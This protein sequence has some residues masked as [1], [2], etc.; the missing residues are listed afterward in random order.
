MRAGVL[1]RQRGGGP[2]GGSHFRGWRLMNPQLSL[3]ALAFLQR[4]A[5]GMRYLP[6]HPLLRA[7]GW[8]SSLT[9]I[10]TAAGALGA[11]S[12][13]W[14]AILLAALVAML[15]CRRPPVLLCAAA[16]LAVL[17]F[18]GLLSTGSSGLVEMLLPAIPLALAGCGVDRLMERS[19]QGL[20][21]SCLVLPGLLCLLI[22]LVG[23]SIPGGSPSALAGAALR[24]GLAPAGEGRRITLSTGAAAWLEMPAAGGPRLGA[25]FLHGARPH[26]SR[27]PAA[28]QVRRA[29]LE[30]GLVV[31]SV[32]H[33]GYGASPVPPADS[34]LSAWDPLPT[35]EAALLALRK[36]SGVEGVIVVGHLT[37]AIDALRLLAADRTLSGA[38]LLGPEFPDRQR[39]TGTLG[40]SRFHSDR[41]MEKRI[42][43]RLYRRISRSFYDPEETVARLPAVH[44]PLLFVTFEEDDESTAA[45]RDRLY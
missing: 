45:A 1:A 42:S 44:A 31:L 4:A 38:V 40:Y 19:R 11:W 5:G 32:D 14:P 26:G 34:D 36:V 7:I 29:L 10:W 2:G 41:G 21:A 20:A 6:V 9:A 12:P 15:D 33:P 24:M 8:L 25:L 17:A 35:G 13:L 28:F 23:P 27:Q 39:E 18:C 16:D 30:A 3:L 43:W 37:G 22:G